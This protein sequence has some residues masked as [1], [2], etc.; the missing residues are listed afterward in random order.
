MNEAG[1]QANILIVDDKPE[2][3]LALEAVLQDLDQ[4]IVRAYTGLR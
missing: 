3:L 1:A 2:N 4:R